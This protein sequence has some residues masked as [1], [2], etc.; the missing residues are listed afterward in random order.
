MGNA[1]YKGVYRDICYV[2]ALS[3]GRFVLYNDI[4][5]LLQAYTSAN[6]RVV[7]SYLL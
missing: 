7:L 4:Y 2:A 1:A 3:K 6:Y 5:W